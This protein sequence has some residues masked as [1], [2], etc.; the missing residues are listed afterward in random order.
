MQGEAEEWCSSSCQPRL[1][2]VEG[3]FCQLLISTLCAM[4]GSDRPAGHEAVACQQ[5]VAA[6]VGVSVTQCA[7]KGSRKCD[8][9]APYQQVN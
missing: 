9:V 4:R 8:A 7:F 5:R 3:S 2:L 1:M 6:A